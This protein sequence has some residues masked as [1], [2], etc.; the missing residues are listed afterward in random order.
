MHLEGGLD[1]SGVGMV[2]GRENSQ[3]EQEPGGENEIYADIF[4]RLK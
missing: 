3:A 2:C 1:G 4:H